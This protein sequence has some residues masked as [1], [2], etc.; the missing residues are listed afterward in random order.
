MT[1]TL[2]NETSGKKGKKGAPNCGKS[3]RFG[4]HRKVKKEGVGM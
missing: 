4:E 1:K 2:E 3:G